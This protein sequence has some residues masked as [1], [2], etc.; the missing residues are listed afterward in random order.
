MY[1]VCAMVLWTPHPIYINDC[2]LDYCQCNEEDRE[3]REDREDGEDC[4]CNSL[5][6]YAAVCASSGVVIPSWRDD[7]LCCK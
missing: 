3:G 6:T 2:I 7:Y 5:A 1:L 4:Y